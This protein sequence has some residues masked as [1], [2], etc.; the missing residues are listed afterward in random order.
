LEKLLVAASLRIE[1]ISESRVVIFRY[2]V[3]RNKGKS[4]LHMSSSAKPV[5]AMLV[6]KTHHQ[7]PS[8]SNKLLVPTAKSL[9]A[10][11]PSLRSAAPQ[12]RR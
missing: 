2:A 1:S 9:R 6:I 7:A 4:E 8:P 3:A 11:V 5:S 10:L 12:Q